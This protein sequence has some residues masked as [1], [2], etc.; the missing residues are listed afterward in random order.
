MEILGTLGL[1]VVMLII[2]C[3]MGGGTGGNC[4]IKEKP[5][6]PKPPAPKPRHPTGR[7]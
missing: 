2:A 7:K 3:F 1:I 6:G 5:K 4:H